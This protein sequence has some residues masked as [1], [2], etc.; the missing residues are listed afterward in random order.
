MQTGLKMCSSFFICE[1]HLIVLSSISKHIKDEGKKKGKKEEK[2]LFIRTK[3]SMQM[4]G[5]VPFIRLQNDT[6]NN[7]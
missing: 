2:K 6:L 1:L 7:S 5:V 3:H 4:F